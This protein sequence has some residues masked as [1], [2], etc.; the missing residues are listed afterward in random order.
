MH[1]LVKPL[2]MLKPV[3]EKVGY[4]DTQDS[5]YNE[6]QDPPGSDATRRHVA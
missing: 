5:L 2:P 1:G 3:S 6:E 4:G